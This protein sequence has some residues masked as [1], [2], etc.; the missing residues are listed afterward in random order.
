MDICPGSFRDGYDLTAC[1]EQGLG[2][3]GGSGGCGPRSGHL[4][5][6]LAPVFDD[7][8]LARCVD[9]GKD[10]DFDPVPGALEPPSHL[11][12]QAFEGLAKARLDNKCWPTALAPGW[13]GGAPARV[14]LAPPRS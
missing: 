11:H 5:E 1:G 3:T 8:F 12:P 2:D 9:F 7:Q 10:D 13:R 14:S 4:L 6:M